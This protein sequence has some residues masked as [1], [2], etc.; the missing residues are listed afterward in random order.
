MRELK[1]NGVKSFA[2]FATKDSA[3]IVRLLGICKG[4]TY[5][6]LEKEP[7]RNDPAEDVE[8]VELSTESL[9]EI[10]DLDAM[11]FGI[12]RPEWVESLLK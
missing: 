3:R 1:N 10:V 7:A 2:L 6:A 11:V 9:Y 4:Q 8:I 12:A 5:T